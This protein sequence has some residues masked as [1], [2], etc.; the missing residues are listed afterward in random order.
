[1]KDNIGK[2]SVRLFVFI[3]AFSLFLFS[4][5]PVNAIE[6]EDIEFDMNSNF[7]IEYILEIIENTPAF[8]SFLSDLWELDE[9]IIAVS[10]EFPSLSAGLEAYGWFISLQKVVWKI[11]EDRLLEPYIWDNGGFIAGYGYSNLCVQVCVHPDAEYTDEDIT[12]VMQIIR[13]V[14]LEYGIDVPI[15]VEISSHPEGFDEFYETIGGFESSVEPKSASETRATKRIA[16][17]FYS[18]FVHI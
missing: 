16:A 17:I 15:V 11:N 4:A 10:G 2:I 6:L 1:M 9:N 18:L 14:G 3:F 7:S 8:D 5:L 12:A 13:D